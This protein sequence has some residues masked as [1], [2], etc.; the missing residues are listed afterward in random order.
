MVG[1]A[2]AMAAHNTRY[3]VHLARWEREALA[4]EQVPRLAEAALAEGCESNAVG[5]LAA[6]EGATRREIEHLL[7]PVLR[8]IGLEP[9][10]PDRAL[11]VL[12]EDVARRILAGEIAPFSGA[13][14][15]SLLSACRQR[16]GPIWEQV[17]PFIGLASEWEDH[18]D[19]RAAHDADIIGR[20]P[21]AARPRWT[22]PL[23]ALPLRTR[24]AYPLRMECGSSVP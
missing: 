1:N 21:S 23:N 4:P 12:V 10:G 20:S 11:S 16:E 3:L 15:I 13:R 9:L 24:S 19:G 17:R 18:T 2:E 5:M 8:E 14:E 6:S 22:Q 7:P